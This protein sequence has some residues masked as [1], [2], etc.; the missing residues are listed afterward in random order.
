MP[1]QDPRALIS[2]LLSTRGVRFIGVGCAATATDFF[3]FNLLIA[4]TTDPT[5]SRVVIVN[6]SA[7]VCATI[8]SYL[9][10]SRLTF[11]A[12][13]DQA[14]FVRYIAVAI[15]GAVIYDG[16]LVGLMHATAADSVVA[17]NLVKVL[18]S[19][20]SATWNFAG[21]SLFVFKDAG[22]QSVAAQSEAR[23]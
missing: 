12:P 2:L 7:F 9:L 1:S 8:V 21:F 18:A 10:N 16:V 4:G 19:A 14:A 11:G 23:L 13:I 22:T 20:L 15:V 17:L 6:T 3:I 5:W